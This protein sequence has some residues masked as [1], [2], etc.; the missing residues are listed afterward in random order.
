MIEPHQDEVNL[1]H[2]FEFAYRWLQKEG[3]VQL[4]TSAGARFAAQASMTARGPHSGEPVIR[5]FQRGIE[6]RG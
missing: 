4:K 2:T 5:F 3:I 6:T 1:Q